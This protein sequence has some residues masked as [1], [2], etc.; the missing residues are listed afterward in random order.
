MTADGSTV[1]L[2]RGHWIFDLDGTLTQPL[3]DFAAIRATLGVPA[4]RGILEY[5]Q[6]LPEPE[7]SQRNRQLTELE[8][9]LARRAAPNPGASPLLRWLATQGVRLGILTRNRR[10]CVD[11]ALQR[12]AVEHLFD[13]DAIIACED[14]SP[15]PDP[16]GIHRLLGYWGASADDALIVGDYRYDLEAGRAAGIAT[17]LLHTGRPETWPALTDLTVASLDELQRRRALLC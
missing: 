7:R 11:I 6:A 13:G 16:A 3:H 12:L 9:A 17:V 1:L 14:A 10:Q 5:I 8:L 15:K 4:E 2:R